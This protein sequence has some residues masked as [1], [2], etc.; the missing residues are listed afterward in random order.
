MSAPRI[1]ILMAVYE[2]DM[3]YLAQQLESLNAQ[4][5]PNLFLYVRDDCSPTTPHEAIAACVQAH[6]TAFPFEIS[7]NARNLGSNGT[8]EAL[9]AGAEGDYFAYC[10]Q[11]DIWLP[12]K[13]TTL[14]ADMEREDAQ[15]VCSDMYVIL[16]Q[17]NEIADRIVKVRRHQI[18]KS[19]EGL[20]AG[21]LTHNFVTG[22]TMLIRAET[23]KAAIPFCPY[24]V[25]DQYLALFSAV[26]GHIFSEPRPLV[27]YRLHG[28]NQTG[29]MAGVTDKASYCRVRIDESIRKFE[30]LQAHFPCDAALSAAMERDLS[31]LC[32]RQ[33]YWREGKGAAA[34]WRLRDCGK[35]ITFFEMFAAHMSERLFLFFISLYRKNII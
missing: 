33:R 7:R 35:Q 12:D 23:A 2:P 31:W 32:A 19:G 30:W 26:R 11:D 29:A 22:C 13:L 8:F 14:L 1:A 15:L 34:L 25:H 6:I 24:M 3:D 16:A 9:T 10:D 21:L 20:A 4:T 5:Y 28:G 27:R 18:L 17:G